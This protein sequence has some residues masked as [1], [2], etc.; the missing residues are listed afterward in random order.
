MVHLQRHLGVN[1]YISLHPCLLHTAVYEQSHVLS[2]TKLRH[3]SKG[4][5]L[6]FKQVPLLFHVDNVEIS[7][8]QTDGQTEG[9]SA[10][11]TVVD[12]IIIPTN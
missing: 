8:G 2:F 6:H 1:G 9:F 5:S 11:Y 7:A 4:C 3:G 10:L 12:D